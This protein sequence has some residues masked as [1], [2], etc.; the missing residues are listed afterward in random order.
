MDQKGVYATATD[1]SIASR[2]N[3]IYKPQL[4]EK[5]RCG[6]DNAVANGRIP[7]SYAY[8]YRP[9][10]GA[11]GE[12]VIDENQAKIVL[13]IFT[14]YAAGHST[15]TI[16]ADLTR[17]CVPSP[18]VLS[19]EQGW[20]HHLESSVQHRRSAWSRH[21]RQ[22]SMY[23]RDTLERSLDNSQPGDA[24]ENRSAAIQKNATS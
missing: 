24:E 23:W 7:G 2:Y 1:I 10:P 11:P 13:R 5:V 17:E 12:R 3:T 19:E 15:R 9:R 16:A 22:R 4:T 8:G 21:Y 18:E 14:E 20:S 6:H